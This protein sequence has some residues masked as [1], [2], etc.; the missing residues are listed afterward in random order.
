L[1]L[2][3]SIAAILKGNSGGIVGLLFLRLRIGPGILA[4]DRRHREVLWNAVIART[5]TLLRESDALVRMESHGCAVILPGLRT[6]AQVILAAN[7]IARALELP[8]PVLGST[9]RAAFSLGAVW[10]PEHGRSA[11]DLIRC[12]ELAV[13]QALLREKAVVQF[14]DSLL[15]VA[16]QEARIE[17]ELT[18]ALEDGQL[19]IHVQPQIDLTSGRCVGGEVLLRWIASDGADVAPLHLLEAARR[20]GAGPQLT[21]WLMFGVCRTLAELIRAGADIRLSVNLMARDV[22]DQE[23]PLLVD[24]AIKFWRVPPSRL[25]VE[26]VESAM[27]E[28]PAAAAVVMGR[29][30][31]LGVT[32]SIDDFGIGYS[33]ILYLRQLPLRELKIDCVFV[34]AMAHSHQD[35]DIV[36]ALIGLAHGLDLRVV[37]EGVEDE[38]TFKLLGQMGCDCAQG[39]WISRAMPTTDFPAWALAWNQRHS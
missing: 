19:R 7:K 35:R 20:T 31:E 23:L 5:R 22:M 34:S 27:L 26:L 33:S 4:L 37:A 14:D 12:G 39:Y 18:Q 6:H 25:T 30:N 21:R 1:I 2:S 11:D 16:R 24:Q 32:T 36:A 10:S 28:D 15:A 38:E 13:E 9:I 3:E 8:L 17:T 29:L